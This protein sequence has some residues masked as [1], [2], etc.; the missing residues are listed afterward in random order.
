MP[1][2]GGDLGLLR[3]LFRLA[4]LG[5][6]LLDALGDVSCGQ[7]RAANCAQCPQGNGAPWCNGD[8]EWDSKA[9]A[10]VVPSEGEQDLYELLELS[11]SADASEI[12]KSYRRLSV[13][14][15]PDKTPGKADKFNGIRDAYEVL[16]NAD[17]R[18]LYDTGG[19]KAVKNAKEAEV[20]E[21]LE[22]ELELS[23]A[24][25]YTGA[26]R[27]IRFTRRIICRKCRRTQDPVRCKGCTSCPASRKMV[28]YR[29]GNM[30][31]QQEQEEP[32]SEDCKAETSEVDVAVDPGSYVGDTIVF[33]HYASQKPGQIPGDLRVVLKLRAPVG[34]EKA[35]KRSGKDLRHRLN[36]SL[37]EALLGF[38]RR[39]LHL[40]GHTLEV[41]SRAVSKVGQVVRITGEGMPVK[42]AP[43][44]FGDLNLIVAVAFPEALTEAERLELEG[45]AALRTIS[46]AAASPGS[47]RGAKSEL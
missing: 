6:C 35:W 13:L 36:L 46:A 23:M 14:Y 42:D 7:H 45:T 16:S 34:A 28:Q 32:S 5:L 9:N 15:H 18:V 12:K 1:V 29:R 39:I 25:F 27:K 41:T 40:D 38:T 26:S 20:G 24:E 2:L 21:G 44:Q 19:M 47:A 37:R 31:F 8:C 11:D 22:K 4:L 33:K 17:S 30:I 10:C 3:P 43:S